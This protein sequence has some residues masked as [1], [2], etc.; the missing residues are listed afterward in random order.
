LTWALQDPSDAGRAYVE[1]PL[2]EIGGDQA[3]AALQRA[4]RDEDEDV[5]EAATAVLRQLTGKRAG[6]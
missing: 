4:L 2:A 1:E 5:R 3:I 6:K